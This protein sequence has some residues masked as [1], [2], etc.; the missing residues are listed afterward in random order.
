MTTKDE[1]I[2]QLNDVKSGI[3]DVGTQL[4]KAQGEIVAKVAALEAAINASGDIPPDVVSALADLKTSVSGL[5]TTA[6]ALDDVVPDTS[7]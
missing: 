4:T 6:Q 5:K 1:F 7:A 3:S 2:A